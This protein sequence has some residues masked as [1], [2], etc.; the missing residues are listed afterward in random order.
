[1]KHVLVLLN[2]R[3]QISFQADNR[4]L[5]TKRLPFDRVQTHAGHTI[6]GLKYVFFIL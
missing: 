3:F 6:A 4:Y 1:M 2:V 5:K